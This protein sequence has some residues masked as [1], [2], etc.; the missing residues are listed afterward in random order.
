[1]DINFGRIIAT[2]KVWSHFVNKFMHKSIFKQYGCQEDDQ[3]FVPS[4]NFL[5]NKV[6]IILMEL[7]IGRLLRQLINK[8]LADTEILEIQDRLQNC[9]LI[10]LNN[11]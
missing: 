8:R 7:L 9:N 5:E 2:I 10:Q 4:L 6:H 11:H 3:N 1:M